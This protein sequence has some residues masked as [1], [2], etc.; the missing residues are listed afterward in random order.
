MAWRSEVRVT[1]ADVD[2]VDQDAA[3]I[4]VAQALQQGQGRGL[5]G[6]GGPDQG[7]GLAGL[8]GEGEVEHALVGAGEAVGEALELDAAG[9]ARPGPR[10]PGRRARRSLVG[11][12]RRRRRR[13]WGPG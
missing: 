3:G 4:G 7:H 2:A 1:R 8:G 5:A 6:A 11:Q 10:R 13:P 9:D 12:E